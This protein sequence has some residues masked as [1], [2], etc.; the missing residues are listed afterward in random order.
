MLMP[1]LLGPSEMETAVLATAL[2]SDLSEK[3]AMFRFSVP[4]LMASALMAWEKE[5][6]PVLETMPDPEREPLEKSLAL[7]P[8]P[9]ICQKRVVPGSTFLVLTV[10]VRVP[11]SLMDEAEGFSV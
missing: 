9:E 11:P 5:K 3:R 7:M 8:V 6:T 4:S 10:V 2:E 1:P